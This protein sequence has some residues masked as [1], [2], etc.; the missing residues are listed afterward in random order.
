LLD[1]DVAR[2]RR[3]E[4]QYTRKALV[5][6]ESGRRAVWKEITSVGHDGTTADRWLSC[7]R[8]PGR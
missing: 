1:R 5:R 4:Q 7:F 2:A 8:A 3:E 6:T